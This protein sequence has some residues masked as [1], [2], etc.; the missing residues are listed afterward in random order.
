MG[1]IAGPDG[2][3]PLLN[4]AWAGPPVRID[5]A[6]PPVDHL[7]ASG[8]VVLA[9]GG[10]QA[11][12]DVGPV[13]PPHLPAHAHAD[14]LSFVLWADGEQVLVDPGTYLY[15]GPER[16]RFRG[17]AA[18]STVEVDGADQCRFWGDFRAAGRPNVTVGRI[19]SSDGATVVDAAHDGYRRLADPV[20]HRRAFAWVPGSGIV[21][22]DR[23]DCS[24]RTGSARPCGR[25]TARRPRARR[26]GPFAI[27][28]LGG[29]PSVGVRADHVSPYL[30]TMRP[31]AAL[32]DRRTVGPGD[33]FGWSL[34]RDPA[35]VIE[36]DATRV[37]LR[38]V[39]GTE[40]TLPL[41]WSAPDPAGV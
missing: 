5:G 39:D 13:C 15:S 35:G 7:A 22:V 26:V 14:V 31:A 36:L 25:R 27:E 18:H 32:E 11:V 38:T 20:V 2:S 17:T 19:E 41:S 24:R 40:L 9:S 34:L 23:L 8:Y 6:R 30:G 29:A 4:D 3:L 16:D 37:V 21:V 1:R 33:V 10:D 28:A 12:L